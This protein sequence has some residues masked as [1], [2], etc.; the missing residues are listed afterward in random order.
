MESIASGNM[1]KTKTLDDFRSLMASTESYLNE[2]ALR[3]PSYFEGVSAYK[4]EDITLEAMKMVCK[5][6]AFTPDDFVLVSGLSFP[7]IV[8][9]DTYGVEVK[10]TQSDH[11]KSTGSSI[12]E[13]TRNRKVE[14][15]YMLFGKLGGTPQFRCRPY[16]ECLY[17]ITVTHSPRYL[18]DMNIA[19]A[20]TIFSKM[21]VDYEELRNSPKSIAKVRKYYRDKAKA[22]NRNDMP[23]WLDE[24]PEANQEMMLRFWGSLPQ[25][26]KDRIKRQIYVL[27]P[28]RIIKKDYSEPAMWLVAYH[29]V[30]CPNMR[31]LFSAGG[32]AKCLNGMRLPNPVP[33]IVKRFLDVA[34]S[35]PAIIE[36]NKE[37]VELYNPAICP[38]VTTPTSD[39]FNSWVEE[40]DKL[41]KANFGADVHFAEW[42]VT[43]SRLTI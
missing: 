28:E 43:D 25:N 9:A 16:E 34:K 15:I 5:G 32:Q 23:W 10:S 24:S 14:H 41:M 33:A 21:G 38:S 22:D 7:D 8:V 19:E 1:G 17:D 11:W 40:V 4:L 2:L 29:K 37:I 27:F 6:T 18:I 30:V 12:I 35:V 39:V 3:D 42:V 20:E 36:D 13:S 31:D 26:D